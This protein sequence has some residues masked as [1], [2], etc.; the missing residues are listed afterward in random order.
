[1]RKWLYVLV[2]LFFALFLIWPSQF[3]FQK[4]IVIL[5]PAEEVY[6]YLVNLESWNE[7]SPWFEDSQKTQFQFSGLQG[8]VGST[9]EWTNDSN[10]SIQHTLTSLEEPH[11]I[12]TD[13]IHKDSNPMTGQ[14]QFSIAEIDGGIKLTLMIQGRVQS[15]LGHL[16]SPFAGYLWAS[17]SLKALEKLKSQL[18]NKPSPIIDSP[19]TPE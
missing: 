3:K 17:P 12:I 5:R 6:S 13:F 14:S 10:L 4:S 16:L 18:E 11:Q 8:V 15:Q 7:W 1:M 19:P 9:A 2:T